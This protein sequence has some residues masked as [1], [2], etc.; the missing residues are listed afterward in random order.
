MNKFNCFEEYFSPNTKF[1]SF[2][3]EISY[4]AAKK[5]D[6]EYKLAMA[7]LVGALVDAVSR[8]NLANRADALDWLSGGGSFSWFCEVTGLD[9]GYVLGKIDQLLLEV[10]DKGPDLINTMLPG[11]KRAL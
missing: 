11:R 5:K 8:K 4:Y 10:N 2:C 1:G 6:P 3:L 7:V 9:R